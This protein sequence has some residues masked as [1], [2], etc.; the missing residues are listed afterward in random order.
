[1]NRADLHSEDLAYAAGLGERRQDEYLLGRA[2]A[3]QVCRELGFSRSPAIGRAKSGAPLWPPG[4][5]G[6]IS[7]KHRTAVAAAA[8]EGELLSVGVDIEVLGP[9]ALRLISR[10]AIEVEQSWIHEDATKAELRA[11]IV[12]SAKEAV[13]KAVSPRFD[14]FLG[15]HD[16]L[17]EPVGEN[18]LLA[19]VLSKV[20]VS[21]DVGFQMDD[22][23]IVTG[24]TLSR[25]AGQAA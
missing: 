20:D 25:A 24:A 9:R 8:R 10:T 7:H 21:L 17:L 2:A 6:S 19:T 5:I 13:F 14:V 12:F 11:L 16:V 3:V 22:R 23:H 18:S 1:M 4:V 15:F